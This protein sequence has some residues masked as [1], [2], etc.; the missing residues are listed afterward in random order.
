M[1]KLFDR[2]LP[3]GQAAQALGVSVK[4]LK[5]Y[6]DIHEFLIEGTHWQHGPLCNSPRLWNVE[7]C[8]KAMAYRGRV[9][10][11]VQA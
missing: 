10:Q 8:R 2:W 5:R 1:E 11:Q 6:A 7:A 3:S 9:R 4:S